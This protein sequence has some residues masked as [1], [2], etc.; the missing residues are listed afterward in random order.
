MS[1]LV[2]IGAGIFSFVL[3]YTAFQVEKVHFG[4]KI[5]A[6]FFSAISLLL[7]G[8]AGISGEQYCEHLVSNTTYVA[9]SNT[10]LYNYVYQCEP[11]ATN[12][13]N[14]FYKLTIWHL[15]LLSTYAMLFLLYLALK[16][17]QVVS[18][19]GKFRRGNR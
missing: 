6:L 11:P 7:M 9:G 15:V 4:W 1:E 3:L 16:Y 19:M 8:Q 2:V 17:V 14:S 10:T 18:K 13:A 5:I 12:I